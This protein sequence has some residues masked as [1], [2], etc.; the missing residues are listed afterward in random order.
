MEP[1][2]YSLF[3]LNNINNDKVIS[4]LGTFSSELFALDY[5]KELY[6]K[7]IEETI[8]EC[9]TSLSKN[10]LTEFEL[11][12]TKLSLVSTRND[13]EKLKTLSPTQDS[14]KEFIKIIGGGMVDFSIVRHRINEVLKN[15]NNL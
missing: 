12:T 10:G 15:T 3:I 2:L 4:F 14:L 8:L 1:E 13:L 7:R 6:Q 9:E 5:L 11:E